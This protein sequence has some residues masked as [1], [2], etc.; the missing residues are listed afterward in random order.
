MKIEN[1]QLNNQITGVGGVGTSQPKTDRVAK[2]P[3]F[4]DTLTALEGL[5]YNRP[6]SS[7][8]APTTGL[9]P[10]AVAPGLQPNAVKFSNHA[11]DRMVSRGITFGP[12]ELQR[13]NDAVEKAAAKGSKNS[14]LLMDNSALIVSVNNK[15][16]VTVMDKT[17]MKENVFTNIDSTVVM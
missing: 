2:G 5:Q 16:V 1:G 14:L 10:T 13:I 17:A 7:P 9:P 12:Q 8:V 6:T 4:Q 15:T 11:I 3:S